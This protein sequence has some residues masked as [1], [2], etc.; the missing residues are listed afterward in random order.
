MEK[1]DK[2]EQI[3]KDFK[4]FWMALPLEEQPKRKRKVITYR[5]I[6]KH[7]KDFLVYLGSFI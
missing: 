3:E 2:W 1:E 4:D 5:Q 7:I 6:W